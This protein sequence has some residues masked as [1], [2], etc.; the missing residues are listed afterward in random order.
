VTD[1]K[2]VNMHEAKTNLSALVKSAVDGEPF[3]IAVDGAPKVKVTAYDRRAR[4]PR[5][6][7]LKGY[8]KIPDDFDHIGRDEIEAL[9]NGENP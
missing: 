9:F 8:G 6:G 2:Q 5:I 1:L 3:I 4:T 7:F